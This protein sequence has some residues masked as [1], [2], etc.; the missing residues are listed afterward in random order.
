M[1][2]FLIGIVLII[3][4]LYLR[5]HAL[6]EQVAHRTHKVQMDIVAILAVISL[7]THNHLYWIA[8][9]LLAFVQLPDFTT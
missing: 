6:P 9:L 1:T 3:G 5:L 7:F 8:A 4:N 2:V